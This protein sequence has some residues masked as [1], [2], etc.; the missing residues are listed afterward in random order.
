MQLEVEERL[1]DGGGGKEGDEDEVDERRGEE[2][3]RVR[4]PEGVSAPSFSTGK[5]IPSDES[6]CN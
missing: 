3:E 6:S 4:L 1:E 2:K 5:R